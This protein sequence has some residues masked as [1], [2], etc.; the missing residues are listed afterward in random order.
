M[1]LPRLDGFAKTLW[2]LSWAFWA[3]DGKFM[4]ESKLFKE[5]SKFNPNKSIASND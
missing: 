5:H 1:G 3:R 2:M 4:T